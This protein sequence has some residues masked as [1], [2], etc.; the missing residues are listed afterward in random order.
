MELPLFSG[1]NLLLRIP[2]G[3]IWDE[4]VPRAISSCADRSSQRRSKI[5][6]SLWNLFKFSYLFVLQLQISLLAV[7]VVLTFLPLTLVNVQNHFTQNR[8]TNSFEFRKFWHIQSC[9]LTT[10]Q[11]VFAALIKIFETKGGEKYPVACCGD[12]E[13]PGRICTLFISL[14]LST[15]PPQSIDMWMHAHSYSNF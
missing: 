3:P 2:F 10:L 13:M 15:F 4:K 11:D 8:Q 1:A 5:A 14:C 7:F 6:I 12:D 9:T